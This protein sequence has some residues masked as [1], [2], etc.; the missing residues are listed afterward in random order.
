MQ[1]RI[2]EAAASKVILVH[3]VATN[4]GVIGSYIDG[5]GGNCYRGWEVDLLPTGS[6]LICESG[7]SEQGTCDGPE[8]TDVC[9]RV[10]TALVEAHAQDIAG[11]IRGEFDSNLD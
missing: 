4:I 6:R 11:E 10:G 3:R 5:V 7:R 9:T 8:V 1:R 2:V